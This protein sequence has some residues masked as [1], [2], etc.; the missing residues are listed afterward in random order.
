MQGKRSGGGRIVFTLYATCSLL[1]GR[2]P[3]IANIPRGIDA[4]CINNTLDEREGIRTQTEDSEDGDTQ[5][6]IEIN[7][8]ANFDEDR[9]LDDEHDNDQTTLQLA[10]E[11]GSESRQAAS[12]FLKGRKDKKLNSR[13]GVEAQMLNCAREDIQL[14]RKLIDCAF[15]ALSTPTRAVT[16]L[17]QLMYIEK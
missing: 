12:T 9:L 1:W 11:I 3:S 6:N 16:F 7:S 5:S 14:K 2:L 8:V 13:L 4:S 15:H 10:Q 17:Q